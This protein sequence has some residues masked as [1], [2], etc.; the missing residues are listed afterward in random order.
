MNRDG[1][2]VRMDNS[3]S[4]Y[5]HQ[6]NSCSACGAEAEPEEEHCSKCGEAEEGEERCSQCGDDICSSCDGRCEWCRWVQDAVPHHPVVMALGKVV[7]TLCR[8]GTPLVVVKGQCCFS[9]S[10]AEVIAALVHA[11]ETK[12]YIYYY[13]QDLD[14]LRDDGEMYISFGSRADG[15]QAYR[16]V[17]ELICASLRDQSDLK[18]VWDGNPGVRIRVGSSRER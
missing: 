15:P 3:K 8:T 12:G 11:P 6:A 5:R 9:C 10:R 13:A 18:V 1:K 2:P 4:E 16:R 14:D 17:G 7:E